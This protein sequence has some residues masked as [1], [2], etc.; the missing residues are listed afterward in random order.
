M[1]DRGV[2]AVLY[3]D[4]MYAATSL[5]GFTE[6]YIRYATGSHAI[7]RMMDHL[8][9]QIVE[10]T[11]RKAQTCRE[12]DVIFLTGG[13]EI[14]TPPMMP[15]QAFA[16][17]VVPYQRMLIEI[18]HDAGHLAMIH[19][20]GRVR[21]VLDHM[22]ETGVDAIEPIEPPPQGDITLEELIRHTGGQLGFLG[23]IPDQALHT[24]PRGAITRHVQQIA[25]IVKGGSGYVMAPT[26]TPFQHPV[27]DTFLRNYSE[28]M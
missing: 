10:D 27:T 3:S 24:A 28:W 13:P 16:E 6:F 15:P 26:C 7:R 25:K 9:E 4:P 5:F 12:M 2:I 23:Y 1:G 21:Q 19:C 18:I 20:H 22:V 11:R 8:F 17:L 14:A